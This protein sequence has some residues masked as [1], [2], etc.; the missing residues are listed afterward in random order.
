LHIQLFHLFIKR[1]SL[2]DTSPFLIERNT[3]YELVMY[4]FLGVFD[5]L[6]GLTDVSTGMQCFVADMPV[7]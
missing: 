1:E 7:T 2:S 6:S 4:E 5:L 3:Q